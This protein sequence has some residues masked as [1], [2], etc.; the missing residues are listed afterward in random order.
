M[1][2][3]MTYWE[4]TIG[5]KI[6]EIDVE[7]A[8]FGY[9]MAPVT[10]WKTLIADEEVCV[11]RG[12][13]TIIK[14]KTVEVP[15]NTIV[16][17]L[18]IM[19]HALG[20]VIDVV[21]CGVPGRVEDEKCIRHVLFLPVDSG[22]VKEGDLVGVLNVVFVRT[23]L[24]SRLIKLKTP[25]VELREEITEANL[26]WRDNGNVFREKYTTEVFWYTT[27]FIGVW[28]TVIAAETVKVRKGEVVR[29]K[30]KEINLPPNTVIVPM[31]VTFNA[32]G[33]LV[34]LV[35][36]GKPSKVEES[37]TIRQAIFLPVSD[38]V[39]EEG[40]LLGVINVYYVG[41]KNTKTAPIEKK[42]EKVGLVY[43]SGEG[44]VR[45]EI[46]VEPFVYRLSHDA[47]WELII[48]KEDREIK[49]GEP[50]VISIEPVRLPKN[51]IT[52]PFSIMRHAFGAFLDV[53]LH[54][55]PKKVEDEDRTVRKVVF[56]PVLDGRVKKGE[57]LGILNIYHVNLGPISKLRLW[58]Q[59]WREG[60]EGAFQD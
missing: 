31:G 41:L 30:I 12:E 47:R 60:L 20:T 58:L 32:Y 46:I 43:R 57:I 5:G 19:R 51:T 42:P 34:D 36:L 33:S 1:K 35:E 22:E 39:I 29:V 53:Y 17:P 49:R 21:E 28:E 48:S 4:D 2:V 23:G 37:K 16:G 6:E 26:T 11:E 52:Y 7:L 44:I 9:K 24:L 25:R 3:K 54:G 18:H 40:D 59:Q 50:C 15:E 8:P 10:Q 13:P 56:L 14:I 55:P 45:K 27:S 38:G